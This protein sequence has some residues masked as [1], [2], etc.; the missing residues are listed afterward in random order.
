MSPSDDSDVVSERETQFVEQSG[1]EDVLWAV[2]EI[3]AERGKLYKV[4][5]AGVD[6]KTG[7]PWAQS[8]V[9]KHDCTDDLVVEWKKKKL[10]GKKRGACRVVLSFVLLSFLRRR[11]VWGCFL[12]LF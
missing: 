9:P 3:T 5:W 8:W 1:D 4:K 7:K 11:V 12:F 6:P 2:Q 10:A